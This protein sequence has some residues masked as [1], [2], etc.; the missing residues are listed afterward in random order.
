MLF[1]QDPSLHKIRFQT[2]WSGEL[3]AERVAGEGESRNATKI[4]I[5]LPTFKGDTLTAS[6]ISAE[7]ALKSVKE[8]AGLL[9]VGEDQIVGAVHYEF[10]GKSAIVQLAPEV[11]LEGLKYDPRE[12][13]SV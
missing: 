5:Y 12:F 3:R 6:V 10:L 7:E 13:V 2:R 9:G 11:D 8:N 1:S 4:Q